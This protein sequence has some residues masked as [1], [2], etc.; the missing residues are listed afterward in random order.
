[1]NEE[2]LA[3]LAEYDIELKRMRDIITETIRLLE[4]AQTSKALSILMEALK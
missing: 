3:I 2:S 4:N 1:M